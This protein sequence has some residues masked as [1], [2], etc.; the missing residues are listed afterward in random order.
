MDAEEA[1]VSGDGHRVRVLVAL[2]NL[3]MKSDSGY[4]GRK[5]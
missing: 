1:R 3:R 4:E 5:R 2:I